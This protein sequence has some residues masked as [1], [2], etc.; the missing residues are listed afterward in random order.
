MINPPPPLHP[1]LI[2]PS[3]IRPY[4]ARPTQPTYSLNLGRLGLTQPMARLGVGFSQGII[5]IR[6]LLLAK[7][8]HLLKIR[9]KFCFIYFLF[10]SDIVRLKSIYLSLSRKVKFSFLQIN[11]LLGNVK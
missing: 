2:P 7:L 1:T 3:D 10:F 9:Y 11:A 8:S 6:D 4:M 5:S